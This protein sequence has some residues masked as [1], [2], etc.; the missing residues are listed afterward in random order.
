MACDAVASNA[1]DFVDCSG[2]QA[3]QARTGGCD[4]SLVQLG[5]LLLP[6][7]GPAFEHEADGPAVA[8]VRGQMPDEESRIHNL[9]AEVCAGES[10]KLESSPSL[11][12]SFPKAFDHIQEQLQAQIKLNQAPSI[13]LRVRDFGPS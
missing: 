13:V 2:A 10:G 4:A 1:G 5:F 8:A 9:R 12:P 3:H 6:L 11:H 7:A